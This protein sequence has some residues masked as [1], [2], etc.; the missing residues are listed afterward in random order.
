MAAEGSSRCRAA[1]R[2]SELRHSPVLAA[3]QPGKSSASPLQSS[4]SC[5]SAGESLQNGTFPRAL[6]APRSA[7]GPGGYLGI[8]LPTIGPSPI[9][10]V[11]VRSWSCS[12][13]AASIYLHEAVD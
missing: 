11:P 13:P 9:S 7:P 12:H 1:C 6:C 8:R 3:A 10:C 2:T 5:P 4:F